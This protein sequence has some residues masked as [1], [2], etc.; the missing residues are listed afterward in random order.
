[1]AGY[2]WQPVLSSFYA[3]EKTDPYAISYF[4]MRDINNVAGSYLR[5]FLNFTVWSDTSKI[6]K[7]VDVDG[8][9]KTLPLDIRGRVIDII[10][11]YAPSLTAHKGLH[12]SF[13]LP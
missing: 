6:K 3:K 4:M 13:Y 12:N 5:N 7:H 2:S 8:W 1:M 10:H 9:L 11:L